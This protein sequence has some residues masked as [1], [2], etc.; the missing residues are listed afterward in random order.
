MSLLEMEKWLQK[1]LP[2]PL[3]RKE[4]I[5][6]AGIFKQN[7]V[8]VEPFTVFESGKSVNYPQLRA[9]THVY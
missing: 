4:N 6:I 5:R 7:Q 1:P 8:L 3:K 9:H 2:Q